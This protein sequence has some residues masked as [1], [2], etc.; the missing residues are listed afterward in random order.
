MIAYQVVNY[1]RQIL[2]QNEI[3]YSWKTIVE[4]MKTQTCSMISME[5]KNNK[6]IYTKLCTRPS[7]EVKK[8]YDA[9]AFKDRPYVR[10]TKV[11]TQM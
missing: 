1:I 9:L 10:K 7:V 6:R 11:V 8:I 3:N 5:A 2:K 4:K